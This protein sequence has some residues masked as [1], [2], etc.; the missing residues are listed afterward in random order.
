MLG[1][2]FE[3]VGLRLGP[4]VGRDGAR[5]FHLSPERSNKLTEPALAQCL[6]GGVQV[7]RL[8]PDHWGVA[9]DLRCPRLLGIEELCPTADSSGNSLF[10]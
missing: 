3:L 1:K 9:R 5:G 8:W 7:G 10:G 2:G 6:R 4:E